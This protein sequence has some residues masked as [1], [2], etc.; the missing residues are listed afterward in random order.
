MEAVIT[1]K[2]AKKH[3]TKEREAKGE[4]KRI[5]RGRGKKK[6]RKRDRNTEGCDTRR[7]RRRER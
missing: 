6:G 4:R 5:Q 2:G 7:T 3:S 1:N